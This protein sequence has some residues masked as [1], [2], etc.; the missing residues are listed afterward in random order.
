MMGGYADIDEMQRRA[1]ELC[2]EARRLS[3]PSPSRRP[4]AS[5]PPRRPE[6]ELPAGVKASIVGPALGR[7][8]NRDIFGCADA[9]GL[10][11]EYAP[12]AMLQRR[13]RPNTLITG[14]IF[15][16]LIQIADSLSGPERH[17][18][19]AHEV[20][21]YLLGADELACD[22][23][24]KFFLQAELPETPASRW[25]AMQQQA[26]ERQRRRAAGAR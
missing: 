19:C 17:R 4:S 8:H 22:M 26:L 16:K 15:G 9:L 20:A 18:V 24:A 13:D 11:V 12:L 21:H 6:K 10:Q 2:S 14:R 3:A 1:N 5:G 25:H 23:F 7:R